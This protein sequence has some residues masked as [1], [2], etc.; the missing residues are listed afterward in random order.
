MK[1]A[2]LCPRYHPY[3]GGVETHVK[4]ISERLVKKHFE[5]EVLTTDSSGKLPKEEIINCVKVRRF[6]SWAPNENYHISEE[7]RKYLMRNSNDYDIIHAHSYHDFPAFYAAEAKRE[8]KFIFAPHYHGT[9]HT[10]LRSLLHIP[11]KFLGKKIFEKADK[12]ICVSNFEKSLILRNFKVDV[13]KVV[14]IPNG[15]NLQEFRDLKKQVRNYKIILYVG[16]LERYKGVHYL[17]EVLPKLDDYIVLEIVGKGP[18]K[19]YLV[20]LAKKLKVENRVRFFQDLPRSRLLQKYADADLFVLLSKHEA[21]AI[22][23][24]EALA[25][26]TPCIVS[27][28]SALQEWIDNENC[29]GVS[30]PINFNKLA[31][32]INNIIGKNIAIKNIL[33]SKLL[34]WN[35]VT[36][37][38]VKLYKCC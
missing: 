27:N 19:R 21:Y 12:I 4:E 16:R 14:V 20:K 37:K 38:L 10:F 28:T 35:E 32:L 7:L 15:L 5:V 29:F 3:I 23:V 11:Y 25:S 36:E 17:I 9:G 22:S 30:Y 33:E 24:A 8:N 26:G 18:F 13:K 1:I 34:D 2:Q 6:K 31:S